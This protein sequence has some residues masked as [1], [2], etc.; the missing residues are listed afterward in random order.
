MDESRPAL[1][2]LEELVISQD[3]FFVYSINEKLPAETRKHWELRSKSKD[4][5]QYAEL[6]S[7]LKERAQ[8]KQQHR[9]KTVVVCHKKKLTWDICILS[10]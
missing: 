7:F 1:Q 5:Q 4:P 3:I 10:C 9:N 2:N 6:L 8:A